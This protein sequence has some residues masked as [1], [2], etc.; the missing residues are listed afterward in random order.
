MAEN[1]KAALKSEINVNLKLYCRGRII[2]QQS[3]FLSK[4]SGEVEVATNI[5]TTSKYLPPWKLTFTPF[6][7]TEIAMYLI[8][9]SSIAVLLNFFLAVS[10]GSKQ[11]CRVKYKIRIHALDLLFDVL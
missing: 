8:Q 9:H 5:Y 11:N 10:F 3:Q 7:S 2:Q 4:W 1:R 6:S